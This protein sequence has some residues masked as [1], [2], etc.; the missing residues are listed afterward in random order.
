MNAEI[1]AASIT[2]LLFGFI[3]GVSV[4]GLYTFDEIQKL[5]NALDNAIDTMFEKDMQIDE[6][7]EE[8]KDLKKRHEKL[9]TA[10]VNT[11]R[12]LDETESTS[13]SEQDSTD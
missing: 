8:L 4:K 1:Y 3:F 10:F 13:I 11:V 2:S 5:T 12:L 6:L 7:T 9:T